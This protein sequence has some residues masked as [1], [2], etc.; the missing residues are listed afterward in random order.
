MSQFDFATNTWSGIQVDR[1]E[2]KVL[3]FRETVLKCLRSTPEKVFE[4]CDDD[5]SK[6]T[7]SQVEVLAVR[8]AKNLQT[9]GVQP[10]DVISVFFKNNSLV[11]PLVFGCFLIGAPINPIVCQN[12]NV[13]WIRAT[14]AISRPKVIILDSC[15]DSHELIATTLHEMGLNPLIFLIGKDQEHFSGNLLKIDELFKETGNEKCFK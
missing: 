3:S 8:V 12:M 14:F 7:Y 1:S 9:F 13:E 5:G 15:S 2:Y 10:H 4:I 11:A 6:T